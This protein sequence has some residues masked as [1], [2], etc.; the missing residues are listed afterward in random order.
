MMHSMT[1]QRR[2][3]ACIMCTPDSRY[4]AI[5]QMKLIPDH[6]SPLMNLS[7]GSLRSHGSQTHTQGFS[8]SGFQPDVEHQ[9]A[10]RDTLGRLKLPEV[11]VHAEN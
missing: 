3:G 10:L 4:A 6:L 5:H 1:A 11:K 7:G 8:N 2:S 9:A